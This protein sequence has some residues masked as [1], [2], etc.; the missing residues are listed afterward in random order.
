MIRSDARIIRQFLAFTGV[1]AV[2]TAGH[3]LTLILLVE[4]FNVDPVI[5]TSLGFVVGALINYILNYKYTFAS[6]SPHGRTLLRFL[7]V[8]LVG[9]LVNSGIMYLGTTVFSFNYLVI[10]VI[11]TAIVL[12][13]NFILNRIWTFAVSGDVQ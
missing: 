2:G 13:Q 3:Y 9:A 6:T 8:A 10:Q 5:A 12:L 4:G 7:I 11:A 1:G